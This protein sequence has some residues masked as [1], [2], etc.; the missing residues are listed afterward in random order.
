MG[1][2]EHRKMRLASLLVP[3]SATRVQN[4][5]Y[6]NNS[7]IIQSKVFTLNFKYSVEHRKLPSCESELQFI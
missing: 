5:N 6:F 7:R 3:K 4:R 2:Q 1:S